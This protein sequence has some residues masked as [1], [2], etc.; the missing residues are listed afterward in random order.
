M[1]AVSTCNETLIQNPAL[2]LMTNFPTYYQCFPRPS[3]NAVEVPK[4]EK[5]ILPEIPL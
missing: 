2:K 1:A 5:K 4:K 3:Q